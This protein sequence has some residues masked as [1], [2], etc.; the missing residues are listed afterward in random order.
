M[1]VRLRPT[2]VAIDRPRVDG[3]L[4]APNPARLGR[5]I[6]DLFPR[7]LRRQEFRRLQMLLWAYRM[8]RLLKQFVRR[9]LAPMASEIL[10]PHYKPEPVDVQTQQHPD[11]TPGLYPMQAVARVPL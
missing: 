10:P 4:P 9:L 1:R 8:R 3:Q 11:A 7:G 5:D 2:G 6:K